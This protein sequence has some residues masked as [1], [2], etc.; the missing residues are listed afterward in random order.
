MLRLRLWILFFYRSRN[1]F[2]DWITFGFIDFIC[3]SCQRFNTNKVFHFSHLRLWLFRDELLLFFFS[4]FI[5]SIIRN[6]NWC[7]ITAVKNLTI[8]TKLWLAWLFFRFLRLSDNL[9]LSCLRLFNFNCLLHRWFL[10][11]KQFSLYCY[12]FCFLLIGLLTSSLGRPFLCCFFI[13]AYIYLD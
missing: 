2:N 11:I 12:L 1:R 3:L 10:K 7:R 6:S 9:S 8:C 5:N 13:L 4:S